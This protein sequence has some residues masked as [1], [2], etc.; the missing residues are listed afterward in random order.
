MADRKLTALTAVSDLADT[1][2]LYVVDGVASTP[3][4]KKI[5][6]A[7]L[8]TAVIGDVEDT[9]SMIP[10]SLDDLAAVGT[11]TGSVSEPFLNFAAGSVQNARV[12]V[13]PPAWTQAR[14]VI[15]W[16]PVDAPANPS[17]FV[18][19][20]VRNERITA[21][22]ETYPGTN[23][24]LLTV[25]TDTLVQGQVY[26]DTFDTFTVEPEKVFMMNIQ[27]RGDQDDYAGNARVLFVGLERVS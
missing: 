25:D 10:I 13:R 26:A 6:G 17:V 22:G 12:M 9:L 18:R 19:L 11:A 4:S 27:R 23:G 21:V 3:S 8:K 20:Q 16:Y 24:S 2:L 15:W 7:D 5:T 14:W 1:D